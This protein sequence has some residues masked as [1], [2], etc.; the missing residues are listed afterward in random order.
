MSR[1]V[2]RWRRGGVKRPPRGGSPLPVGCSSPRR[3]R[4]R[5][6][7]EPKLRR[8]CSTKP[9]PRGRR[10]VRRSVSEVRGEPAAR[11]RWRHDLEPRFCHEKQ[12]KIATPGRL[13]RSAR[14]GTTRRS[15]EREKW[16]SSTR[17]A[18]TSLPGDVTLRSRGRRRVDVTLDGTLSTRR[19]GAHR[20]R[21][22]AGEHRLE[23]TGPGRRSGRPRFRSANKNRSRSSFLRSRT[24]AGTTCQVA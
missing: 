9:V 13:P 24:K 18:R 16:R 1:S 17:S 22:I 11:P 19:S 20:C 4:P 3:L 7:I 6:P 14:N 21:S 10:K 15:G 23:A 12:G 2:G 5:R 8:C